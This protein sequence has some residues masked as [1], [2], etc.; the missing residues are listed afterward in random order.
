MSFSH[1]FG[2]VGTFCHESITFSTQLVH[3]LFE[4]FDVSLFAEACVF[5]VFSVAFSVKVGSVRYNVELNEPFN[6]SAGMTDENLLVCFT[7]DSQRCFTVNGKCETKRIRAFIF[8][9]P[10][11]S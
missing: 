1:E 5:G 11:S 8:V 6:L 4:A 3:G 2:G 10:K 9:L 7:S